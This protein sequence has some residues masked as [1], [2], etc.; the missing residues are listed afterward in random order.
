MD[1]PRSYDVAVVANFDS[2]G[3]VRFCTKH[4]QHLL[5]VELARNLSEHMASVDFGST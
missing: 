4:P 5:V 3:D 1:L 2:L